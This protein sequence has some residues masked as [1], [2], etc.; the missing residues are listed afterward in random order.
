M[1]KLAL[2]NIVLFLPLLLGADNGTYQPPQSAQMPDGRIVHAISEREKPFDLYQDMQPYGPKKNKHEH[3]LNF[4][5]FNLGYERILMDSVYV[6]A[7]IKGTPFYTLDGTDKHT[8]NHFFNGELRM[9]YN[10]GITN[11]DTLTSYGGIGFS[12]FKLEKKDGNIRDW[13]YATLGTKYLHQFGEIFEMGIHLKTYRSIQEK[14]STIIENKK[15]KV[16]LTIDN[17]SVF[18]QSV[19]VKDTRWMLEVGIPM[20]WHLGETK[21]WEIQ[22]EPY[23]MQIPNAKILHLIGSRLSFGFR[24]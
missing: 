2:A 22:L 9:G 5:F 3:R 13:N 20:I 17:D 24:F 4:G 11:N 23:Y 1:K 18:T 16:D 10:F 7:D 21:N 19:S 8:L 15:S 14:R 12:V 6:G